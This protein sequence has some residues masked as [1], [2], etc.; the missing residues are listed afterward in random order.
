[1]LW[2]SATPLYNN[3][4]S[5]D[6]SSIDEAYRQ[7]ENQCL[8]YG[9][10]ARG[11]MSLQWTSGG[12]H[13]INWEVKDGE[14]M[15]IDN[16]KMGRDTRESFNRADPAHIDVVRL[17]DAIV[18]P[19]V[20][21]FIEPSEGYTGMQAISNQRLFPETLNLKEKEIEEENKSLTKKEVN[22]IIKKLHENEKEKKTVKTVLAKIGKTVLNGAKKVIQKG[23][24]V[25]KKV[26][27]YIKNVVSPTNDSRSFVERLL[28]IKH[29]TTT[30][31]RTR[32]S[33]K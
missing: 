32:G 23:K 2:S 30:T 11:M 29:V 28:N 17:D 14:F 33:Y 3:G 18:R 5:V 9:E 4:F 20:M 7:I 13:A 25:V 24:E 8:G 6:S 22:D 19:G 27:K 15:L 26:L 10:G 31:N 16:Q 21:D 1:M 12:G